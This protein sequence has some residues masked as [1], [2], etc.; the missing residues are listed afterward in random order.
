MLLVLLFSCNRITERKS[1]YAVHGI[2]ISRYQK[3]I[4][5][6]SIVNSNIHFAFIKAT[7]GKEHIDSFYCKNWNDLGSKAIKKGAYH[8]FRPSVPAHQQFLNYSSIVSLSDG[9]LPPV[10]DFEVTGKLSDREINTILTD[11][12]DL[13]QEHYQTKPI[14]YTNLKLYNKHI[15]SS[16]DHYPIWIARYSSETPLLTHGKSWAF[17]Q[18]GNRGR[19]PG[20]VGDVD[21]NVFHGSLE[22]LDSLCL[23]GLNL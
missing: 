19:I 1:E 9:D 17:W 5:W 3:Q 6:D 2:D 11:L 12:L 20:I 22:E 16:F 13:L 14:I 10:L 23:M 15:A 21:L 4:N 18:Y 7:E 8:F